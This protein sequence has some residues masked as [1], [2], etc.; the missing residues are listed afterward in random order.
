MSPAVVL[1]IGFVALVLTAGFRDALSFTIPNWIS[2][3]LATAFPLAA[4][5][6]GMSWPVMGLNL[7][8]GAAALIAG[9]LL[10]ALGW[11]GGG[12]AKLLAAVA[13]WLGWP[14]TTT[15]LVATAITGGTLAVLLIS[16]RSTQ[17]RPLILLGP[18][19]VARLAEPGEG[20]PY[21]VA[22]AAGACAALPMTLF[23]ASLG[24]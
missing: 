1:S 19:W 5:A 10:F 9:M 11:I 8:I 12:D 23:G 4:L 3:C 13:L 15:F 18:R 2:L 24:L 17:L 7:G 21:G 16:V 22:I 20:V 14:A 6:V